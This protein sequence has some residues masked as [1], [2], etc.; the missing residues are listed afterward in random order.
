M[1]T[2]RT[3]LLALEAFAD[4]LTTDTD[5]ETLIVEGSRTFDC[6]DRI[7]DLVTQSVATA[8]PVTGKTEGE[9]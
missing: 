7:R 5:P 6:L 4:R 9:A 2:L 1:S 8:L 3:E